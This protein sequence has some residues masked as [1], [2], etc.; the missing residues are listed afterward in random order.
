MVSG[1]GGER[2]LP[3]LVM[4]RPTLDGLPPVEVAA[5]YRLRSMR[6]GEGSAWTRIVNEA[7]G[8]EPRPD[9]FETTMRGDPAFRPERILFIT[10]DDEPVAT[11]SA[12]VEAKRGDET[13]V[14][15]YVATRPDHAGKHLGAAVSVAALHRMVEENRSCAVL[16]TDDFRL[17]ALKT[18]LRLGFE[19]VLVHENQRERWRAAFTVLGRPD[20]IAR[21][22]DVLAGPVTPLPEADGGHHED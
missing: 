17:A 10:R 9:R 13:G 2:L 16:L 8:D 14:L 20:L 5:G 3:Q 22:A 4:R 15:H 21:F 18:Y 19:P 7:F 12:W 6:R 1:S 11:A